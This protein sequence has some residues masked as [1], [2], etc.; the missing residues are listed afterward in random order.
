[1]SL[2]QHEPTQPQLQVSAAG[3]QIPGLFSHLLVMLGSFA[4]VSIKQN[5]F[6]L[7]RLNILR[8]ELNSIC[9]DTTCSTLRTEVWEGHLF[10]SSK[11]LKRWA[12]ILH[13]LDSLENVLGS[14][15]N[16][17]AFV[18]NDN[19]PGRDVCESLTISNRQ[20]RKSTES[21]LFPCESFRNGGTASLKRSQ[22]SPTHPHLSLLG[23]FAP[24]AS[25]FRS[26]SAPMKTIM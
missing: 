12:C 24:S 19:H 6:W 11:F 1:M 17:E 9:Q 16:L 4:S 22:H 8:L 15:V 7:Q 26:I 20:A 2:E 10:L 3:L 25:I 18:A 5:R 21:H 13:H 23:L 14:P